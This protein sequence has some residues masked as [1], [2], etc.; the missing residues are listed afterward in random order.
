[1]KVGERKAVDRVIERSEPRVQGT[2]AMQI[3]CP[4][5]AKQLDTFVGRERRQPG[6]NPVCPGRQIM[7]QG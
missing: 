7:E 2:G 5:Q 1:M 3:P 4:D 6:K